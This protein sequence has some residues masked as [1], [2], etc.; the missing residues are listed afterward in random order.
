MADYSKDLKGWRALTKKMR[1]SGDLVLV[2]GAPDSPAASG[3][4]Q[5][6][7]LAIHE[8]GTKDGHIPARPIL[9]TVL[10]EQRQ[11]VIERIQRDIGPVLAGSKDIR[12]LLAR[13]GLMLEGKVKD[14]FGTDTFLGKRVPNAPATIEAKGSSAPLIDDGALRASITHDVMRAEEVKQ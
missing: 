4:T 5:G 8:Y 3:L 10:R 13:A 12:W 11:S 6:A 2:V 9:Q 7:L 14:T 1:Q